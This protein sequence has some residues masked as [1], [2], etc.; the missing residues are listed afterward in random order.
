MA[1]ENI[2]NIIK[3][4]HPLERKLLEVMKA[5]KPLT[6]ESL[7]KA[8]GLKQVEVMRA[9]QWLSNKKIIELTSIKKKLIFLDSNGQKVKEAGLPEKRVI[10]FLKKKKQASLSVL[11]NEFGEVIGFSIGLLKKK[12]AITTE[13]TDKGLILK[14][15]KV[16]EKLLEKESLEEKFLKKNFPLNEDNLSP[17]DKF[18]IDSLKS[19]KSF[20]K[21]ETKNVYTI[22]ITKLFTDIIKQ[23]MFN[24]S[25]IEKLSP[26]ILKSGLWR[27]MKFRPYDIHADVPMLN[28]G[29]SHY[30]NQAIDHIKKIWLSMGFQEMR[31]TKAQSA[32]WDMDSLF[33]PQDHP[34]REMQDTFYLDVKP[35]KLPKVFD[36][37]KK[38]HEQGDEESKGWGG[39]FKKEISSQ[40]MLRTHTTVLSALEIANLKEE[41]LPKKFFK[42]DK[43]YRNEA[44]DWK[45][46]FELHQVEGIVVDENANFTHLLG[47]LKEF[48]AKL[49]HNKIR[50][51][52]AHFPYT[53]PSVEVE[54]FNKK[55]NAWVELGGAGMLRPEVTKMLFGKEIPVLAWGQGMER[56]ISQYY[57]I[58]DIRDL[59]NNDIKQLRTIKSHLKL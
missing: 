41:D 51:R 24:E 6:L 31:G 44:L 21:L 26:E 15:T 12:A 56:A 39:K 7:Q 32:F 22:K 37:V 50:L 5:S 57:D 3:S 28:I 17:E 16:G 34:A 18:A 47:Y 1:Q 27:T 13:K 59:Y 29:K 52:P 23:K 58:H 49:G 33:V 25:Y 48:Y 42:V 20:L 43:V 4:L 54:Y 2:N 14:I 11:K 8:S 53:E 46:L 36:T 19:R 45:H 38:M 9:L 35:A 40:V 30:V 10:L 55:K